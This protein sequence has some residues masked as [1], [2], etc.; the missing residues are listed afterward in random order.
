M[1]ARLAVVG[2]GAQPRAVAAS[3]DRRQT[4]AMG[5]GPDAQ[6]IPC[7]VV[8]TVRNFRLIVAILVE[9]VLPGPLLYHGQWDID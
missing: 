2:K 7:S 3:P 5:R 6:K 8:L 9:R 1:N 4:R